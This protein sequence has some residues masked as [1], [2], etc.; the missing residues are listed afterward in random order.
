VNRSQNLTYQPIRSSL[1]KFVQQQDYFKN[2]QNLSRSIAVFLKHKDQEI[3]KHLLKMTNTT[4]VV[5]NSS[6]MTNFI[7]ACNYCGDVEYGLKLWFTMIQNCIQPTPYIFGCLLDMLVSNNHVI[8]ALIFLQNSAEY[9]IKPNTVHYSIVLKGC[10]QKKML[11]KALEVYKDMKEKNIFCNCITYNTL[12]NTCIVCNNPTAAA[13][14]VSDMWIRN[15]L[16]PDVVTYSTIIKG[17]CEKKKL[18]DAMDIFFLMFSHDVEPDAIT[19]NTLLEAYSHEESPT[20]MDLIFKSMLQRNI[21]PTPFT[22]TIMIKYLGKQ[23]QL[24]RALTLA[25]DLPYRFHFQKDS[26]VYTAL[27]AACITCND[28]PKALEFFIELNK[29]PYKKIVTARTFRTICFGCLKAKNALAAYAFAYEAADRRLN[30]DPNLIHNIFIAFKE[31]KYPNHPQFHFISSSLISP[32]F[33]KNAISWLQ[34][35]NRYPPRF[36]F[37]ILQK[38]FIQFHLPSNELYY[39]FSY[40]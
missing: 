28:M 40:L 38:I 19:Y 6:T 32:T 17:F 34:R 23:G 21:A 33:I 20:L 37:T 30:I 4:D 25:Q 26:Y 1:I 8:Q 35:Y 36:D 14:I 27:I 5:L 13:F 11:T 2:I 39:L 16:K 10:A 15:K 24:A 12:I 3:I 29:S 22:L 31:L 18:R 7:K 9:S